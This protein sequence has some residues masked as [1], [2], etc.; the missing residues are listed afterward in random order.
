MSG[1]ATS[2]GFRGGRIKRP[3]F[4][5]PPSSSSPALLPYVDAH[6]AGWRV[7]LII[8]ERIAGRTRIRSNVLYIGPA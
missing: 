7:G 8:I 6:G 1:S 3:A 4:C 5:L 2:T